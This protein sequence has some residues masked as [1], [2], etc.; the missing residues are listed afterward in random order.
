MVLD[1]ESVELY[2]RQKEKLESRLDELFELRDELWAK[3]SELYLI[4]KLLGITESN[5]V[6]ME[7]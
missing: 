2:S 5:Y 4:N 1:K 3:Q 7:D 6:E